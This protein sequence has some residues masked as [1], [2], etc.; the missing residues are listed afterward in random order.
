MREYSY[1]T[2]GVTTEDQIAHRNAMIQKQNNL[3]NGLSGGTTVPQFST[4][5]APVG[6]S[7][8]STILK[9]ANLQ[10]KV[11]ASNQYST[12]TGKAAGT[13]G[14]RPRRSKRSR[15]SRRQKKMKSKKKYHKI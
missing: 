9:M 13:C 10:E 3:A 8:N 4:S 14:G 6:N 1:Q 2:T 12:C 5:G 11:D 15:R 7:P